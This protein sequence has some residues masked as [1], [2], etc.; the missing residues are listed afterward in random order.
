MKTPQIRLLFSVFRVV[1][2][3]EYTGVVVEII[4]NQIITPNRLF[5]RQ[6]H[7]NINFCCELPFLA[8]K[9]GGILMQ[10]LYRKPSQLPVVEDFPN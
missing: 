4:D 1:F 3:A 7:P 2:L 9:K 8:I 10:I 6:N 5:C